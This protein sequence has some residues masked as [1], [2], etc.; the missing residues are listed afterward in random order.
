MTPSES[1]TLAYR[2]LH[3]DNLALLVHRGGLH[4]PAHAP[5]NGLVYRA[6]HD[7][8]IQTKRGGWEVP[9]GPGGR[10]TD[11]VSFYLGP[12]SP[13]LYRIWKNQ[14]M[15]YEEGQRPVVYLVTS[16]KKLQE[17]ELDFVFTDG[18]S[19]A[20]MTEWFDDPARLADLPWEDIEATFWF[21]TPEDPDRGRRKQA[22]LLVHQLVPWEALVG[23]AAIDDQ[24][25]SEL[26]KR[27]QSLG[28]EPPHLKARPDW[29][30]GT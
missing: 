14:V 13:M 15:G 8:A 20:T 12:R 28:V 18:H 11:Y 30:Y 23:L 17:L 16:V 27:L 21:D 26:S 25:V 5:A 2:I 22:E 7:Q 3:I 29:Y 1:L 9:C 19:L 6:I 24:M 10:I 4:A